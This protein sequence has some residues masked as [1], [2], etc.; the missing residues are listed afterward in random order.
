MNL[1]Y[2][3]RRFSHEAFI[4]EVVLEAVACGL[5][6]CVNTPGALLLE[7]YDRLPAFEKSVSSE[8]TRT[9]LEENRG[10]TARA[11]LRLISLLIKSGGG[12]DISMG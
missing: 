11:V 10:A 8:S 9:F 6:C 4:V 12:P 3:S 5:T 2:D 1:H 7:I